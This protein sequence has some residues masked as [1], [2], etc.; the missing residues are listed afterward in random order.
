[1]VTGQMVE[2]HFGV[3]G[4]GALPSQID[5]FLRNTSDL[6]WS[7]TL[8]ISFAALNRAGCGSHTLFLIISLG[9]C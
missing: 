9:I 6:T 5:G 4:G 1:M 8:Q 3:F 7:V 2:M